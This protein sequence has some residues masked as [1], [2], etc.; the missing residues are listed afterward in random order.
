MVSVVNKMLYETKTNHKECFKQKR[1]E[2]I[3]KTEE[4][5]LQIGKKK[6]MN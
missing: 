3:K 2:K 6:S 4:R 5:C 1:K